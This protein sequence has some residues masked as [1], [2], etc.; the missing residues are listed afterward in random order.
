MLK[1]TLACV[2]A[3]ALLL[4]S[5]TGCGNKPANIAT[6]DGGEIPAGVYILNEYNQYVNFMNYT[7]Q[8]SLSTKITEEETL[9]E[10]ILSD[11]LLSMK[12]YAAVETECKRLGIELSEEELNGIKGEAKKLYSDNKELYEGKGIG[13]SSV[14]KTGISNTLSMKLLDKL[15]GEGGEME[16]SLEEKNK[17]LNDTYRKAVVID[18]ALRDEEGNLLEGDKKEEAK[19]NAKAEFEAIANGEKSFMEVFKDVNGKRGVEVPS[20]AEAKTYTTLITAE[21]TRFAHDFVVNLF[22]DGEKTYDKPEIYEAEGST[23]IYMLYDVTENNFA[24]ILGSNLIFEMKQ[25]DFSDYLTKKSEE[26]NL[27]FDEGALKTYGIKNIADR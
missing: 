7:G 8:S 9:E 14:E 19:K 2:S 6:F 3:M 24:E 5:L 11:A 1:R 15:Y 23:Y 12:N 4:L 18:I 17:F 20:D 13:L 22:S 25:K 26:I 16:V 10:V 21:D 27:V